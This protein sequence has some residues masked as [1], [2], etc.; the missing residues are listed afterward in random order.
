MKL[1]NNNKAKWRQPTPRK[2]IQNDDSEDDQDLR[3]RMKTRIEKMQKV[4]NKDIEELK[5]KQTDMN[6]TMA[7]I[8]LKKQRNKQQN[9]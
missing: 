2:R 5:N 8:I 6:N 7:K 1:Q 9:E 3:K 4:F